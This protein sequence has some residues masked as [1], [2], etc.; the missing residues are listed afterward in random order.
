MKL[1][2]IDTPGIV[3]RIRSISLRK[4]SPLAPRFMRRSTVALACW[5]GMS[6]YGHSESWRAMV[7]S[8]LLLTRF[9]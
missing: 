2:R 7:S 3:R 9:G 4:M 5:S 6:R 8:S 1:V